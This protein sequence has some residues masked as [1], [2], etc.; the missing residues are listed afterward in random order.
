MLLCKNKINNFSLMKKTLTKFLNFS[1]SSFDKKLILQKLIYKPPF[2]KQLSK[3]LI[4]SKFILL[5]IEMIFG[6]IN[7]ISNLKEFIFSL[8]ELIIL[9]GIFPTISNISLSSYFLSN[10]NPSKNIT[11]L[12]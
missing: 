9:F 6:E 12:L 4:Y 10:L 5:S 8:I 3:S 1:L 7:F 11:K 2:N